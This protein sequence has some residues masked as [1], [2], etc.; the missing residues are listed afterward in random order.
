MKVIANRPLTLTHDGVVLYATPQDVKKKK[1]FDV[2]DLPFW[3]NKH[4]K[5]NLLSIAPE[6]PKKAPVKKEVT[7]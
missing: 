2:P 7:A 5:E 3:T 1:V 6:K 4:K